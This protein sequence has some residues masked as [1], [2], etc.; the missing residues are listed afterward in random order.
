MYRILTVAREYGSGGGPIAEKIAARLGWDLLDNALINKIA[1]HAQVD[2]ALCARYDEML[3]SWVHR[4]AKRA[5][6]R[7][8]FESV[9]GVDIFD[10]DSMAALSRKLIEE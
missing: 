1:K 5:F 8:S 9:A 10:G 4:L 7:G 3:D 6:G 2:P